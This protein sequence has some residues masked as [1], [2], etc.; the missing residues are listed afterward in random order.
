MDREIAR[1]LLKFVND[2]EFQEAVKKYYYGRL[3]QLHK[4]LEQADLSTVACIQ[5][6]I[7]EL[8]RLMT[9]REEVLDKAK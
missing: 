4:D 2:V 9:L 6:Q 5:G 7:K 8:K 3:A 1:D